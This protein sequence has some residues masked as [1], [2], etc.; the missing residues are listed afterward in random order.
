MAML[1]LLELMASQDATTE[2]MF[3]AA[4]HVN[5]FWFPQQTLEQ[6]IYMKVTEKLEYK[7]VDAQLIVGQQLSSGSG[8]QQV[9]QWL[10]NNGLFEQSSGNGSNC[11]V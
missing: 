10:S 6:A 8:F 4:K 2:E 11:G 3:Q 7:D 9:H 5:A 1:G